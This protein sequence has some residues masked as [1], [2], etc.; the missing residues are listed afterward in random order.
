MKQSQKIEL[1][2]IDNGVTRILTYKQCVEIFGKAE[3]TEILLGY[4]PNW[5]AVEVN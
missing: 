1:T 2:N 4:L 5:V 3:F